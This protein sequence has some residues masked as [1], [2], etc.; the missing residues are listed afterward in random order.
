MKEEDLHIDNEEHGWQAID[1]L[2]NANAMSDE[3][4]KENLSDADVRNACRTLLEC[5][6]A[7]YLK[8]GPVPDVDK[9]WQSFEKTQIRLPRREKQ[10]KAVLWSAASIA[11]AAVVALVF[12]LNF[13]NKKSAP[14]GDNSM[15]AF[16]AKHVP[17]HV[18]IGDANKTTDV[19]CVQRD[20]SYIINDKMADFS[21]YV[22]DKVSVRSIATPRGKDY[23]I[24]LNDGTVV[25]MNADSKLTF[26]TRFNT[27]ERGVTLVG[28]AYFKVAKDKKHPFVVYTENVKT[29]VLGTEFNLK[30]YPSSEVHVTLID[31]SII[32]NDNLTQ[33][34]VKLKPGQDAELKGHDF[35][36]KEVDTD[37]YVQWKDGFFY[38]DNVPLIEVMKELGRWYNVDIEITSPALLSYRL[39]FIAD[40]TASVDEVIAN[41][42]CFGYLSV[43]KS[44]NKIIISQKK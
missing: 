24:I 25:L 4:L 23:K 7:K 5:G 3:E 22:S 20:N 26:P 12:I 27:R 32:I 8:E 29:R 17:Q 21:N 40:R 43:R 9:A 10:F 11:A 15:I 41:L 44:G 13:S 19:S 39:H 37:Y 30:A 16:E 42:N 2:D 28:E 18:M 31:G 14:Y 33:H 1:L 35:D 38:F 34:S 36:V 6:E